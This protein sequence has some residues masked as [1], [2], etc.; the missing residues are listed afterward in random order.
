MWL[1][2][3]LASLH[4]LAL[5]MGLAAVWVRG[6]TLRGQLD[7]VALQRMRLGYWMRW[8]FNRPISSVCRWVAP[9][10]NWLPLITRNAHFP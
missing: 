8:R 9:L 5:G 6:R 7:K 4:L 3:I 2:W 1:R 10:P